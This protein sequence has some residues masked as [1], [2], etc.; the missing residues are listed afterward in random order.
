[1]SILRN[2]PPAWRLFVDQVRWHLGEPLNVPAFPLRCQHCTASIRLA[3][4]FLSVTF[5]DADRS[6][7]CDP[8]SHDLIFHHPMPSVL[9]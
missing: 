7:V 5:V 9:G 8:M 3:D 4:E 1:V 6:T 2:F